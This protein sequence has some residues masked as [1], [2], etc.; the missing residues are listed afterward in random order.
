MFLSFWTLN[1]G[2]D[3]FGYS[4]PISYFINY[5]NFVRCL[6]NNLDKRT[7]ICHCCSL[8]V[9]YFG[10]VYLFCKITCDILKA[11]WDFNQNYVKSRGEFGK[12]TFL[13][14]F[15]ILDH[16]ILL[17]LFR[18]LLMFLN[19]FLLFFSYILFWLFLINICTCLLMYGNWIRFHIFLNSSARL[20]LTDSFS[21]LD[22]RDGN[23]L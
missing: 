18:T 2:I 23:F 8:I 20:I 13:W 19:N 12:L 6:I 3:Q 4:M 22:L 10:L 5:C 1:P 7:A 16:S 14:G 9:G 17:H 21:S 11:D 15:T